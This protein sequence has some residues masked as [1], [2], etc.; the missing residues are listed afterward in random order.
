MEINVVV[1]GQTLRPL[2]M[3]Q[4]VSG[5]QDFVK[6]VFHLDDDWLAIANPVS[7]VCAVFKQNETKY[8]VTLDS[9]YSAFLPQAIVAGPCTMVLRGVKNST[10]ATSNILKIQV[11]ENGLIANASSD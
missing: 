11:E 1:Q 3:R 2:P 9:N 6:F 10:V 5:S 4:I 8:N 7:N